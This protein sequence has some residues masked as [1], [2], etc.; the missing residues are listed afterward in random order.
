MKKSDV[1]TSLAFLNTWH[2]KQC[3]CVF[4]DVKN[5][6]RFS[7]VVQCIT[8]IALIKLKKVPEYL[9]SLFEKKEKNYE[10]KK[11]DKETKKDEKTAEPPKPPD[12]KDNEDNWSLDDTE[13]LLTYVSRVFMLQF[14]LYLAAKQAGSR[15]DDL[16]QAEATSLAVFL[17]VSGDVADI[18]LVL[19][20]NVA[21]FCRSGGLLAMT[22]A[23]KQCPSYLPPSTAHGLVSILCNLKL[24]LNPRA[25]AQLFGPVR[26]AALQYMCGLS[27][28]ELRHQPTRAMADFL[29]SSI[30]DNM[31]S[32]FTLDK[33]GLE[34]AFKYFCSPTLTMRLCGINQV[35]AHISLFN[36]MCNTESV[37]EVETIGL[38][39]AQWILDS[40]LI[41]H[42]FG[43]NLHVEVIKQ[44]HVILNFLAMEGKI[45]NVHMDAIWQSAQLKH[46]SKQ[47]HDLLPPLIKNLE[48]GPVLHL[49][50]LV[51]KLPVKEHTEQTIYL[52]QVLQK[53][54]WTSGGTF[55]HLLQEANSGDRNEDHSDIEL[56]GSSKKRKKRCVGDSSDDDDLSDDVLAELAD[57]DDDNDDI[58]EFSDVDDDDDD[59]DD[60]LA[61]SDSDSDLR[62]VREVDSL[63]LR[64]LTNKEVEIE[65]NEHKESMESENK[66]VKTHPPMPSKKG[67]YTPG[68]KIKDSG[69]KRTRE[70]K[71]SESEPEVELALG[72]NV[73]KAKIEGQTEESGR[74]MENLPVPVA[75]CVKGEKTKNNC[76]GGKWSDPG[77]GAVMTELAN[78]V[79]ATGTNISPSRDVHDMFSGPFIRG[80]RT[81][82]FRHDM[83][84]NS[85]EMSD[86]G[87]ANEGDG[88]SPPS[89]HASNKSDKNMGDFADEE[90][91]DEEMVRLAQAEQLGTMLHHHH[92]LAHMAQFYQSRLAAPRLSR[93]QRLEGAKLMAHYRMDRVAEPGNTLLW[94]LIQDGSIELLAEGLA[95]EAE[96]ALTNLLCYNMERFIR[97]KFIEGCLNNLE[98]NRSVVVSLRLLP[99]LFQSFHNF[100]GTDTH[101]ITL[102]TEKTHEM[103]KLFFENL[104][105]YTSEKKQGKA[106]PLYSHTTQIQ[107]RLQFLAMIFSNQVSEEGFRLNQNQV[108]TLWE[109][110]ANDSSTSDDMFQWLLVQAHS[111]DQHALGIDSVRFIHKEKLP[112]LKPEMMTMTGLNLLSQLTTLVQVRQRKHSVGH[113]RN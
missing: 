24:W 25:I 107:A 76:W 13:R 55:S 98:Q 7:L 75:A 95:N 44:S 39:L 4:R 21:R 83:F 104:K 53:F 91:A 11:D 99:K 23:F 10:E 30:K 102:Y 93:R 5:L 29:W 57:L 81:D 74:K 101:E 70:A 12:P 1:M 8:K 14:P 51:Q 37:V 9:K 54:I 94:D 26:T 43:P 84:E 36:E 2:Q 59:E 41:E 61:S 71:I 47:V 18:P 108:S 60:D 78:L 49:Y 20:R 64:T 92:Q 48:A 112:G 45:T 90:S 113:G 73:K 66:E 3:M 85:G 86:D 52:A 72:G 56:K 33:D 22:N 68:K 111:K 103:T 105:R 106:H 16:S 34:L 40:K 27:D 65:K 89:S 19:L 87:S 28:Q 110:L 79:G 50:E 97:V 88:A 82:R 67:K 96:K 63:A 77:Q 100:P 15:L 31:E 109:C 32:P 62:K 80:F 42:I 6:E 69:V 58:D 35:N 17:D 46:C 38:Q